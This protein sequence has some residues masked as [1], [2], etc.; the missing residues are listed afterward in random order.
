MKTFQYTVKEELGMHA[1]PA[2]LIL[3]LAKEFDSKITVS[4]KGKKGNLKR[5]LS[6]V[7]L[8]IQFG[9]TVTVTV[10]GS[11]EEIAAE[12]ML[13]FFEENL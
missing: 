9:D 3:Q 5:L 2:G 10:E 8:D 11:D 4:N 1:R 7:D 13:A 6:V 12:E